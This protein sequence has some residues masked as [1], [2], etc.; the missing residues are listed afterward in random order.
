M[1]IVFPFLGARFANM[2]PPT[3]LSSLAVLARYSETLE[4]SE[5]YFRDHLSGTKER[6]WIFMNVMLFL[7]FLSLPHAS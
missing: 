3:F 4:Y 5:Q 7:I 2:L 6:I 1:V